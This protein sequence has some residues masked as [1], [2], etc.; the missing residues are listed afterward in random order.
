MKIVDYADREMLAISLANELAGDLENALFH[1]DTVSFAVPGGSSPGPVFDVLCASDLDW[2]RVHVML[3]DE[4][5]VP[6]DHARSNTRLIR[7]R[8]LTGR[9]A[10]ARFLPFYAPADHPEDVLAEVTAPLVPELPI[11]VLLLGM[12]ADMHTA[13]LF[14]GAPGLRAALAPDA[15]VL[16][17]Q[18]PPTQDELRV[19][20]S[21]HVL[22][23]AMSK[24]LLIMGDDKREALERAM[25]LPP[26]EAPINAVL[27]ETTVHWAP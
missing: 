20:L 10:K 6:E 25:T 15:P 14:P 23:G 3:T 7:E 1:H 18:E 27:S 4:R 9:A 19:S 24:H 21:A 16:V 12:G 2:S 13:S 17:A 8:L 11:S 26:E 5:W 22:D